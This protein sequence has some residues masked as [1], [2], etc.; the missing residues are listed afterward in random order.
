MNEVTTPTAA[1]PQKFKIAGMDIIAIS[2]DD[3]E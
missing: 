1:E 2:S 3:G